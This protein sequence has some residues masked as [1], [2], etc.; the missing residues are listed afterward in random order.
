VH[1]SGAIAG[2]E[3][4][5]LA[6]EPISDTNRTLR[7]TLVVVGVVAGALLLFFG[8]AVFLLLFAG[9]LYGIFLDGL[10][11]IVTR[12]AKLHRGWALLVVIFTLLFA[13]IALINFL[14]PGVSEQVRILENVLP[15]SIEHLRNY[16]GQFAWGTELIQS[17]PTIDDI[18]AQSNSLF[19]RVGGAVTATMFIVLRVVLV[20]V[21][22]IYAAAEPQRY[23]KGLAHLFAPK[24]QERVLQTIHAVRDRLWWWLVGMAGTMSSLTVLTFIGLTI[25]HIPLALTLSLLTGLL[26]FIPNFGPILS[27][28]PPTLLG[29]MHGPGRAGSVILTYFIIQFLESH[30]VTPLIQRH[31]IRMPPILAI[32]AQLTFGFLFGFLG[33]LLAVPLMAAIVATIQSIRK[34]P[35]SALEHR[36]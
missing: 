6:E 15:R 11:N 10:A 35:N 26:S 12:Y 18:V 13:F 27:A 1:L 36:S 32:T 33:L 2:M 20:M 34:E 23:S 16:I 28:I 17:I 3:K 19:M 30:L 25:C 21:I 5:L 8:H 24:H 7:R 14:A 31:M 4:E 29:L 9:L 22:G